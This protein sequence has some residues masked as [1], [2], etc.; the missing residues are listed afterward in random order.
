MTESRTNLSPLGSSGPEA[1]A[2]PTPGEND[3]LG[4]SKPRSVWNDAWDSLERNPVLDI[5]DSYR[6][7]SG[8]GGRPGYLHLEGPHR[9]QPVSGPAHPFGGTLVWYRYPGV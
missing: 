5:G 8:H 1:M 4:N 2:D 6:R 7:L 9:L 3:V